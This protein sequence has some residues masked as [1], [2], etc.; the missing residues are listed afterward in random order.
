VD[1]ASTR[2]AFIVLFHSQIQTKDREVGLGG[3]MN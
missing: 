1:I 3:P 2:A